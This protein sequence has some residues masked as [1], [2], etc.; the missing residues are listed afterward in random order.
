MRVE[1]GRSVGSMFADD[2]GCREPYNGMRWVGMGPVLLAT[3]PTGWADV[4]VGS[5]RY[6]VG[7]AS[8][9]K[10][11][12]TTAVIRRFEGADNLREATL[13]LQDHLR[14]DRGFDQ[15]FRP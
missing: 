6:A 13:K 3:G 15:D 5:K 11:E 9:L 2:Y 8:W 1:F 4:W 7:P 10:L 14:G 12:Q